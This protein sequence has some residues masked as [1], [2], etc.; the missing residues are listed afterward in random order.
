MLWQRWIGV[1]AAAAVSCIFAASITRVAEAVIT[2]TNIEADLPGTY[3]D[4]VAWADYDGDGDLDL[5]LSGGT[6]G[7]P[8]CNLRHG[9]LVWTLF[10]LQTITAMYSISEGLPGPCD[11]F[12]PA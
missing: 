8:R 11:C 3:Y 12:W 9:S 1:L 5:L 4:S 2:Y 6:G 7:T 10:V